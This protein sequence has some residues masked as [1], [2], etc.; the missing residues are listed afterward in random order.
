MSEDQLDRIE[1]TLADVINEL[2]KLRRDVADQRLE[3]QTGFLEVRTELGTL[4][5]VVLK[6]GDIV[7]G[8]LEINLEDSGRLD[9]LEGRMARSKP[10]SASFAGLAD[11]AARACGCA[12]GHGRRDGYGAAVAQRMPRKPQR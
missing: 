5:R 1:H 10:S 9:A 3:T 6:H 11:I 4:R 2:R 7:D 8:T 12:P